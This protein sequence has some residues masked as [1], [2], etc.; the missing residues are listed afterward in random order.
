MKITPIFYA[1][2]G[3]SLL[4]AT[5][6]TAAPKP[7]IKAAAENKLPEIWQNVPAAQR[8]SL[9]RAAEMDALRILAERIAGLSLDEESTVQ[10]LA[11]TSDTVRG[12]LAAV[13]RGVK[14]TE[15]PTYHDDGRVEVVRAVKI[16]QLVRT[17]TEK[18]GG[19]TKVTLDN[20]QD[21]LDALGNAAIPGS[22]GQKRILAKRAAE[23]DVYRRLA[24]R[25]AGVQIVGETT[26]KDFVANDDKLRASFSHTIKSAEIT[27]IAFNDD[28]TASVEAT[29]KIGPLVRTIVKQKSAQGNVL[30]VEEKTEQMEITE[31]GNGAPTEE[32]ADGSSAPSSKEVDTVIS[33]VL[34]VSP[35]VE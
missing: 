7:V 13:L 17:I 29:L 35:A 11:A 22:L 1:L 12:E 23:M 34:A 10:D 9:V 31:T 14:T 30:K 2:A 28:G 24:E 26:L 33:S 27:S 21:T 8:L 6:A 19:S 18:Q 20:Q 3:L 4:G 32:G 16:N 25:V 5:T 15:G